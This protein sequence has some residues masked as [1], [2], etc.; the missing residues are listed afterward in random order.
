MGFILRG[1]A[2]RHTL[3]SSVAGLEV[4]VGRPVVAEILRES[5]C[6]A[7]S[8]VSDVAGHGHVERVA[9]YDLMDVG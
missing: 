3:V 9:A 1:T 8:L 2:L 4:Q 5:T 6:G 7:R